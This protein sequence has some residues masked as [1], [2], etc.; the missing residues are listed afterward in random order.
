MVREELMLEKEKKRKKGGK[1]G[2]KEGRM[3]GRRKHA[4][5]VL[6]MMTLKERR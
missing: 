5:P 3:E 6:S 4:V 2:G 1:E